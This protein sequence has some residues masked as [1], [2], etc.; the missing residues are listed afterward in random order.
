MDGELTMDQAVQRFRL[1]MVVLSEDRN[2]EDNCRPHPHH[3]GRW[4]KERI[5][6]DR[7]RKL[8]NDVYVYE[9]SLG[10]SRVVKRVSR[11]DSRLTSGY[12]SELDVLRQV[13][14][15]VEYVLPGKEMGRVANCAGCGRS[16]SSSISTGGFRRASMCVS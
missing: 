10:E 13:S 15:A 1:N 5:I 9:S 11:R 6:W 3:P 7:T 14:N 16:S 12:A 8:A 2:R 4:T